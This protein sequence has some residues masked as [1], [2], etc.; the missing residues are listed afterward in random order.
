ML[1]AAGRGQALLVAGNSVRVAFRSVASAS[2]HTLAVTGVDESIIE[3]AAW[4]R[5]AR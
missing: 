1:L 2:E 5:V 3:T 4:S